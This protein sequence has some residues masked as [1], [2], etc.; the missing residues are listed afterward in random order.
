MASIER[1]RVKST[2]YEVVPTEVIDQ[3]MVPE[4]VSSGCC[5]HCQFNF[6]ARDKFVTAIRICGR[7]TGDV[8]YLHPQCASQAIK[9]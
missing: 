6:E 9:P 3:A 5:D 4:W 2:Q 8:L 1:R 7:G